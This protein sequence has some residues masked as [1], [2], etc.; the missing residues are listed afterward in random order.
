[1]LVYTVIKLNKA[2]AV[3][4]ITVFQTYKGVKN[5]KYPTQKR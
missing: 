1:M 3:N 2:S 4:Q 5:K